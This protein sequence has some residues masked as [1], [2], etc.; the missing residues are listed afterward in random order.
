MRKKL[1]IFTQ[2]GGRFGNQMLLF[3]HLYS[4]WKEN[5]N[6]INFITISLWPYLHLLEFTGPKKYGYF[7]TENKHSLLFKS[8]FFIYSHLSNTLKSKFHSLITIGIH[9]IG[10][11]LPNMKSVFSKKD[12]LWSYIR[13]YC[14]G[15]EYD[16]LN[17]IW[18]FSSKHYLSPNTFFL[19]WNHC[20]HI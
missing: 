4:F 15:K 16:Q 8:L 3:I 19:S 6:K 18:F 10:Y 14:L 1:I 20:G 7:S 2:S 17:G 13:K 12:S 5:Q 9:F 11:V